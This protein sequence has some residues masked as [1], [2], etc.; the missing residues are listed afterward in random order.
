MI[1]SHRHLPAK[2]LHTRSSA[3]LL[4]S[5]HL[6]GLNYG[7]VFEGTSRQIFVENN[8]LQDLLQVQ[9]QFLTCAVQA[10]SCHI[11]IRES[12]ESSTLISL[13]DYYSV[14]LT[15]SKHNSNSVQLTDLSDALS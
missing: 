12:A 14:S 7:D 15:S 9:L 5:S 1:V 2:H 4:F 13:C 6:Y 3:N 11:Y 10:D 8:P